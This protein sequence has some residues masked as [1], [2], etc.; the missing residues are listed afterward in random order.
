MHKQSAGPSKTV[1]PGRWN[2]PESTDKHFW[3]FT[4]ELLDVSAASKVTPEFSKD[5]AFHFFSETYNSTPKEFRKPDWLPVPKPATVEFEVD[6]I[7]PEE[8]LTVIKCS[9]SASASSP[10]SF[11]QIPHQSFKRCHSLVPALVNLSNCCWTTGTISSAWK[12]AVT[13]DATTPS[14]FS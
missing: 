2:Q 6:L 7:L 5:K 3:K 8:V 11:D 14:N 4:R 9:K 1:R 13:K 12:S 10:S